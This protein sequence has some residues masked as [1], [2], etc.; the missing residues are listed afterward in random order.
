MVTWMEE[1][2]KI[3]ILDPL[4]APEIFSILHS[5]GCWISG[6]RQVASPL[7]TA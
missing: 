2:E 3:R 5:V 4:A 7:R 6:G 1:F